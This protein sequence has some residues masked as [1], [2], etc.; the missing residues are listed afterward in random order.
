MQHRAMYGVLVSRIDGP[1]THIACSDRRELNRTN[2][3]ESV[4]MPRK[5]T[6]RDKQQLESLLIWDEGE[7]WS[8]ITENTAYYSVTVWVEG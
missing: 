8:L 5:F 6:F 4:N 7:V 2:A 3:L 1:D